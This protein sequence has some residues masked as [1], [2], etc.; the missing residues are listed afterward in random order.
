MMLDGNSTIHRS[1][2]LYYAYLSHNTSSWGPNNTTTSGNT[3]TTGSGSSTSG[4]AAVGDSAGAAIEH[5]FGRPMVLAKLG[6]YIMDIKVSNNSSG[7]ILYIYIYIYIY[8]HCHCHSLFTA[9]LSQRN[10]PKKNGGWTG[11]ALLPFILFSEKQDG[12][13]LV[14]GISPFANLSGGDEITEEQSVRPLGSVLGD[15]HVVYILYFWCHIL[16]VGKYYFSFFY[17][18]FKN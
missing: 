8:I 7:S 13:F 11:S 3:A 12:T 5:T 14:V 15:S 16:L 6:Q 4:K 10:L 1:H 2:R 9:T 17:L 18:Y